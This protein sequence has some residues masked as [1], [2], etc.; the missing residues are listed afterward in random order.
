[1]NVK[2]SF[3]MALKSLKGNKI[4]AFLTMLGIIIGVASVI[5]LV[6]LVDGM[7]QDMVSQFENM[8]TN[9][10]TVSIQGRGATRTVDVE[11]FQQLVSENQDIVAYFSP[12]VE[13]VA[14]VKYKTESTTTSVTGVSEDYDKITQVNIE[15][16]RFLSYIDIERNQKVCI[17]GSYIAQTLFPGSSPLD[18]TLKINGETY[19]VVGVMEEDAGSEAGSS[20]DVIYAPYSSVS[21]LSRNGVISSYHLGATDTDTVEAAV[22]LVDDFLYSVFED[23][24]LY[25]V[26]SQEEMIETVDEMLATV[27]SVLVG[28]AGISLLVGGI[29]IMNIMLVSV[30][31]RTKEI[32]IRKSL[33]AKRK[34]IMRQFVIEASTTSAAGGLIGIVLGIGMAYAAG[35]ML[36]MTVAP[37]FSAVFLAFG[38]SVVIG[39]L[40]GYFPASKAAKLNPIDALRYD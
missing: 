30:I 9:L 29:G 18:Q 33:G 4:R 14:T 40:F 24:D 22:S 12:V 6:S 1:M 39:I 21:K 32:G 17:I 38:V 27:S 16:G 10:V 25:S 8:G 26:T 15:E 36:D 20:D 34:D 19:T 5:V 3:T 11:D 7:A 23:E 13:A 37:T 35:A 2:Q 31:E 28:I